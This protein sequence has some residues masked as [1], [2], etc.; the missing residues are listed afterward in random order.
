MSSCQIGEEFNA[1]AVRETS[2][3]WGEFNAS[4]NLDREKERWKEGKG[5][6]R[7]KEGCRLQC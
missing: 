5:R 6:K 7:E 3:C 1:P 2:L 4:G